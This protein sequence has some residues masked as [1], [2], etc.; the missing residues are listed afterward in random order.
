MCLR[1]SSTVTPCRHQHGEGVRAPFPFGIVVL[2]RLTL[3]AGNRPCRDALFRSCDPLRD[4]G[5]RFVQRL[6]HDITNVGPAC[7][8]AVFKTAVNSLGSETRQLL[9]RKPR[10][11][12]MVGD[13]EIHEK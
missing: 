2:V 1:L 3:P 7:E 4:R 6:T 10:H 5:L 11:L 9:T 13:A 8:I 12:S